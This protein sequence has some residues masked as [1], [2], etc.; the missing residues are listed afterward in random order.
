MLNDNAVK[1]G[2]V[3]AVKCST[4]MKKLKVRLHYNI[5][6]PEKKFLRVWTLQG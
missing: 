6:K 1:I 3:I 4:K 2:V 5:Q